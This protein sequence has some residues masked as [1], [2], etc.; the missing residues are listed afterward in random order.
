M[1]W[2]GA[3]V[4][5]LARHGVEHVCIASGSRSAPLALAFA[6][7]ERFTVHSLLDERSAGFFALGI[8]RASG[9]PAAVVTTSGTAAANLLP[10]AIEAS[11]G[12]SPLLLLTADRP[13]YLRGLDA[14]QTIDQVKLF[15]S[16]VRLFVDVPLP[17]ASDLALRHLRVLAA[18]AISAAGVLPQGPVHLNVQ[19][20]KPL[21][22]T[23]VIGD[24]PDSLF[25]G[26]VEAVRGR[27][28]QV[29]FTRLDGAHS[30]SEGLVERVT[31][32]I[33]RAR[34]GLIVCGPTTRRE[35]GPAVL[36]L[37]AATGFPVLADPLS[38]ARYQRGASTHA[39]AGY[40]LFLAHTPLWESL[41]PDLVIR[42]GAAP[43][44]SSTLRFLDACRDSTQLVIDVGERWKDHL[45][46]AQEYVR[47]DPAELCEAVAGRLEPDVDADWAAS[48]SEL[49]NKT[50][51]VI[52]RAI[53]TEFFEGA[54]AATLSMCLPEESTWFLG[55]S[56]PIRDVDAFAPARDWRLHTIG[57]RGASG[58]DG[59]VSSALGASVAGAGPTVALLGDLTFLHDQNGLLAASRERLPI[60]I[61]VIQNDGGGIFHL[62]PI[63]DYDP[64]FTDRIVMP[65]G[66]D[67]ARISRVYD[68]PHRLADSTAELESAIAEGIEDGGP[69][70]VEIPIR[71][72]RNWKIRNGVLDDVLHALS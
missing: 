5:E 46:R 44:S 57:H 53:E 14:N 15:G 7:D 29:A 19:F 56:M 40:D 49:G 55:N 12:E 34:R 30:A 58:I 9:R 22:P 66:L 37:A 23:P 13:A 21:E 68:I 6:G 60:V 33:G 70:I 39:I 10:A 62:L 38:G 1:L 27:G 26:E 72:E 67:L 11:L 61:V 48:W 25:E 32:R 24:V 51:F 45:A 2:A 50:R 63:R 18:R 20:D 42:I 36:E 17:A 47:V 31:D 54:V 69:R 52:E 28:D 65:H 35:L 4:D 41:D 59:N 8:G 3:L 64:T 16:Y 71:R 43:T